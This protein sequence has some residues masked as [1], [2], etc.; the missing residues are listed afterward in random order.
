MRIALTQLHINI[1]STISYLPST[2][3][4]SHII[5]THALSLCSNITT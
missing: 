4:E 1:I 3:T 5:R 2:D